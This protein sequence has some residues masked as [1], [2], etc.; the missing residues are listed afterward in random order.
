MIWK[1]TDD[2][3]DYAITAE[4]LAISGYTQMA[5]DAK[6]EKTR[7]LLLRFSAEEVGHKRQ[8]QAMKNSRS[9]SKIALDLAAM[10][11]VVTPSSQSVERMTPKEAFAFAVQSEKESEFLYDTLADSTVTDEDIAG[12]FRMLARQE[13]EHAEA[14]QSGD[15][16]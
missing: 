3:L 7:K 16:A 9:F 6:S 10:E 15:F 13:G 4:E 2:V 14:L 12:T 5:T 1:T 11:D 8:L